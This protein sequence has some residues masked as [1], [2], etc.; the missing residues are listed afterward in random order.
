MQ[1]KSTLE[2]FLGVSKLLCD[3]LNFWVPEESVEE[4][5]PFGIGK[6]DAHSGH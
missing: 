1:K 6:G 2:E 3:E 5:G 4:P